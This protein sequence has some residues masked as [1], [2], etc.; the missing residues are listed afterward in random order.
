MEVLQ[1]ERLSNLACY[2]PQQLLQPHLPAEWSQENLAR[3]AKVL[4]YNSQV[5]GSRATSSKP[6]AVSVIQ[7]L[8][9]FYTQFK[10]EP[11]GLQRE[12]LVHAEISLDNLVAMGELLRLPGCGKCVV[13]GSFA[14]NLAAPLQVPSSSARISSDT[15]PVKTC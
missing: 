8:N 14:F 1:E 6:E 12:V 15:R 2:P 3:L 7:F 4:D 11:G 10:K 13:R 5:A 9:W